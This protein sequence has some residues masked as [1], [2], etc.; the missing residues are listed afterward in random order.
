MGREP[1]ET[2]ASPAKD[3]ADPGVEDWTQGRTPR[4]PGEEGEK[5]GEGRVQGP[6]ALADLAKGTTK[7]K[8]RP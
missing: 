2:R 6:P 7:F 5:G 1:S 4:R 8:G 3:G